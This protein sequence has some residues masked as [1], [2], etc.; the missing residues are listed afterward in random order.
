MAYTLYD[1]Y[2]DLVGEEKTEMPSEGLTV[3]KENLSLIAE[4]KSG[5]MVEQWEVNDSLSTTKDL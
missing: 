2:G 1:I 4:V 3:Y 5:N